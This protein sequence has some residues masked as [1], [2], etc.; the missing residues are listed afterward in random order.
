MT[1]NILIVDDE[2]SIREALGKFLQMEHNGV[3]LAKNRR[4]AVERFKTK[5][6]DFVVLDLGLP[7]KEGWHTHDTKW[8][9]G[10]RPRGSTTMEQGYGDISRRLNRS[11]FF[12]HAGSTKSSR[13]RNQ[14]GAVFNKIS[15]SG[16]DFGADLPRQN[17]RTDFSS[18]ER[19]IAYQEFPVSY[20]CEIGSRHASKPFGAVANL[21]LSG[22]RVKT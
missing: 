11:G 10:R 17:R 1:K 21:K 22:N 9:H 16:C 15:G 20:P 14:A 12:R 4:E 18:R 19:Q 6:M 5:K 3:M 13:R 2:S 7:F 8:I